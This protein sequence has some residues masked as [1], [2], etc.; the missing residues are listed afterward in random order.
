MFT[1]TID[2]ELK[3]K[4]LETR[5]A[6]ELFRL[7]D[8]N[9]AYLK[10]WMPWVD[11]TQRPE[12][13]IDYIE[14]ARKQWVNQEG[15]TTC[16]LYRGKIC[17]MID[18]HGI[19]RLNRKAAV[20]YWLSADYQGKGIMTRACRA[21]VDYGFHTLGL[22]RIELSAGVHNKKSRAVAERLGFKQEGIARESQRL[23]DR[24]ID[25]VV[26][27]MLEKEWEQLRIIS[28]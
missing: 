12:D 24:F 23:Y 10:E 11:A 8:A 26:Y 13:T 4:L 22:H 5:D 21:I 7:T 17:G 6:D 16:I 9:R 27:S 25:L 19:S 3:L 15:V 1:Y 20:G 14:T 28:T 2:E 18:L